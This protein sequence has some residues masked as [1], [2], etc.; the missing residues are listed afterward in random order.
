MP[1]VPLADAHDERVD[2]LVQDVDQRDGVDD[3]VVGAVD[4]ELHAGSRE[5]VRQ[6]ELSLLVVAVLQTLEESGEVGAA[7]AHDLADVVVAH[8]RDARLLD[9]GVAQLRVGDAQRELGL[10]GIPHLRE[11]QLEK[12]FEVVRARRLGDV[13]DLIERHRRGGEGLEALQRDNL[14]EAGHV[15]VL[16]WGG[17]KITE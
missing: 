15:A 3:H 9:D 17:G 10:L 7:A 16:K 4:V 1:P 6:A 11:V 14:T 12:V 8:A 2:V 5:R 13:V